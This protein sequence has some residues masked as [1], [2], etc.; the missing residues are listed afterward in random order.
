[1]YFISYSS[2]ASFD[3]NED[4]LKSLLIQSRD[5]N[6]H[7]GITGM[8]FYFDQK[9][10]QLIEGEEDS[11]KLLYADICEDER[12]KHV[13]TLKEGVIENRYFLD[14]S[15]GFKSIS[16]DEMDNLEG[17]QNLQTPT[18]LNFP[19]ILNLMKLVSDKEPLS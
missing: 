11:V 4:Q 14:W 6:Q 17:Y 8:L 1:M 19:S 10:I 3:L 2:Y 16:T 5:R 13:I 12:H 7:M 9:F 15:M 18:G